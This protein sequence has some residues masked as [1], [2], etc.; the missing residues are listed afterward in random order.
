MNEII[1][2]TERKEIETKTGAVLAKAKEM[3][4][5]TR[6]AWTA[7]GKFLN[8]IKTVQK[9]IDDKFD[10]ILKK[11]RAALDEVRALKAE[12]R[13]IPDQAEEAVK[14]AM[15]KYAAKMRQQREEEERAKLE[16]AR[17]E[18]EKQRAKEMA[19][20]ERQ[21]KAAEAERAKELAA[22][23][24]DRDAKALQDMKRLQ[25]EERKREAE[26]AERL[27]N[28]PVAVAPVE[29]KRATPKTD[30][31]TT[32]QIWSA[33]VFDF[34]K[35]VDAVA[36]GT[37]DMDFILPHATMLNAVAREQKS[38]MAVP[39]VKAVSREAIGGEGRS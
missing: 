37:V 26:E 18:A 27:K 3:K 17:K 30:G 28:A 33:E 9:R 11:Q 16:I 34:K 1:A 31:I 25:E 23:K 2:L 14:E 21:R 32:R 38:N 24:K 10:P 20:L 8:D 22:A 12:L 36:A 39:G 35:L 4:V 15:A 5:T 13:R 7:A 6:A 19:E 29:V